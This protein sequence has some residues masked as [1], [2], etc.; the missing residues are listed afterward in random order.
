MRFSEILAKKMDERAETMYRLAKEIKV[1]PSSIKGWLDGKKM[2]H[3]HNLDKLAKHYG[4]SRA[5]MLGNEKT[6]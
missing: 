6:P 3:L 2:P 1:H 5:E 4:V